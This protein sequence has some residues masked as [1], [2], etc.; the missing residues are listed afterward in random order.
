MTKERVVSI[1]EAKNALHPDAIDT[2]S[3]TVIAMSTLTRTTETR[4]TLVPL[5][6]ILCATVLVARVTLPGLAGNER[7]R[8][9]DGVQPGRDSEHRL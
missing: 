3:G 8:H 9:D 4:K 7:R 1:M 6:G 2:D 5:T